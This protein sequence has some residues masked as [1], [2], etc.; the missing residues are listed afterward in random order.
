MASNITSSSV[1]FAHQLYYV[2]N[3]KADSNSSIYLLNE[4]LAQTELNP[5]Q[6]GAKRVEGCAK[7]IPLSAQE[8]AEYEA[9]FQEVEAFKKSSSKEE[10]FELELLQQQVLALKYRT[11]LGLKKETGF[12]TE[13]LIKAFEHLVTQMKADKELYPSES[14]IPLTP[15][16][17]EQIAKACSHYPEFAIALLKR[18]GWVPAIENKTENDTLP[19]YRDKGWT[20]DF[21]K[22]SLRAGLGRGAAGKGNSVGVFVKMVN[23]VKLLT[24]NHIDKRTGI[25]HQTKGIKFVTREVDG[26][27]VKLLALKMR[28]TNA[29]KNGY[30][31]IQDKESFAK[32]I[33]FINPVNSNA[34]PYV[35]TIK[36]F[37]K[38]IRETFNLYSDIEYSADGFVNYHTLK[39]GSYNPQTKSYEKIDCNEA[40]YIKKLPVFA[41]ISRERLQ[42]FYPGQKVPKI[43][44]NAFA[45]SASRLY[46]DTTIF[47]THSFLTLITATEDGQFELRSFGKQQVRQPQTS[48]EKIFQLARA[49]EAGIHTT[50]ASSY[51]PTREGLGK[52][53]ILTDKE[54]NRVLFKLGKQIEKAFKGGIY[55]EWMGDSCASLPMKIYNEIFGMRI[56]KKLEMLSTELLKK[57]I[58]GANV[59]KLLKRAQKYH[60]DAAL[61]QLLKRLLPKLLVAKNDEKVVDL[62]Q[63]IVDLLK[64]TLFKDDETK[65]NKLDTLITALHSP[66]T[67]EN[68]GLKENEKIAAANLK[69]A[70][71]NLVK[72]GVHS[73]QYFKIELLDGK[74]TG[75]LGKIVACIRKLP[76]KWLRNLVITLVLLLLGSFCWFKKKI[77]KGKR[78]SLIT[79]PFHSRHIFWLPTI[80]A[81]D[82]KKMPVKQDQCLASLESAVK[83]LNLFRKATAQPACAG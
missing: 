3:K 48:T 40:D 29:D 57:D 43:G 58:S 71:D 7:T 66:S 21:L 45:L 18:N 11:G 72:E 44:E 68:T 56:A 39:Q 54:Y 77:G 23:H 26:K 55:F 1:A 33:S 25:S 27:I 32:K 53:L 13:Q 46:A 22:W 12:T 78:H 5:V 52:I 42:E 80:L 2:K 31:T 79:H 24:A 82:L 67:E 62:M 41:R 28:A 14:P 4:K 15:Y 19:I 50:D 51:L 10:K 36:E 9:L 20:T 16:D 81:E 38:E 69:T 8:R 60:D 65:C 75:V 6:K 63:T 74:F 61:E 70:L 47:S 83:A 34:P 73:Q 76:F 59:K 35:L 17:K 49:V 37:Y 64:T 30:V